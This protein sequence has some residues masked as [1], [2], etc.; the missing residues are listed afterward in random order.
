MRRRFIR[1][2]AQQMASIR[3]YAQFL[4]LKR[5]NARGIKQANKHVMLSSMCYNLKKYLKFISRKAKVNFI[6][7]SILSAVNHLF[8]PIL[9]LFKGIQFS[10]PNG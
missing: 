1:N 2:A 9:G 10:Q 5:V 4:N 7:R 8:A 6:E 3:H